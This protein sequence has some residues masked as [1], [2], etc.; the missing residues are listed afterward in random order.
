M[1]IPHRCSRCQARHAFKFHWQTYRKVM[2]CTQCG[3]T[4]FYVDKTRQK[5]DS[6]QQSC[7]CDAY[8]YPHRRGSGQCVHGPDPY[9]HVS[10]EPPITKYEAPEDEDLPF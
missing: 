5:R 4:R 10:F 2:Q 6:G 3:Y 8:H 1:R 9:G 7:E